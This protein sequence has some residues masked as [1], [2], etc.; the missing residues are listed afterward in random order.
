MPQ[1]S[2]VWNLAQQAQALTQ[3]QWVTDPLFDYTTLLLQADNA[4]N[5]AQNNTFL[6]SS[7]NAFAITRN[8]NTTQGT[9]SPFSQQPGNWSV[10]FG[11]SGNYASSSSTVISST[12][13]TFTIEGWIYQTAATVGTNIPSIIGDMSPTS[14]SA[15]WSFGT[16][17]SGALSFYWYDGSNSLSAV[18]TTTVP[19]NTW[20][21]IA[22]SVNSNT[23]SM[24]INGVQQ[25]LTG[26]TTLTNRGGTNTLTTF[27][28]F[29]AGTTGLYTGYISNFSVLSGTAK[30]SGSFTPSSTPLA[31]GTTNQT[32][33][34]ASSNRFVDANTATTAKTFTITGSATSVQAFSPFAPQ[35]QWTSDVIGGSGYFDGTGDYLSV[36]RNNA[37]LP[38][39]NTDFTFEAWV[40][41]TATPGAQGAII[42]GL[43]EYGTDSDWDLDIN[44][45]LQFALYLNS[46]TATSFRNTT[47][48]VKLNAWNH[49]AAS[50]SGTG[51]NNLKVFVNGVGQ[52]FTTNQTSVGTG[53]RNLSIGADQDGTEAAFTGYISGLRL[54]N[55]QGIY[56]SDFTPPTAPPTTTSGGVTAANTALLLNFT[57]AGIYD[58]TMK[59]DL[60][61][62]ANA[63]VSTSVVK[64]GSGSLYFDGTGDYLIMPFSPW[65]SFGA[66]DFTIEAWV[67]PNSL[68]SAQ[69]IG[70]FRKDSPSVNSDVGWDIY[71]G[72]NNASNEA[73]IYSSTTK[74]AVTGWSLTAGQ[75][76]HI[77]FVRRNGYLLFF[78]NGVQQGSTTSANVSVNSGTTWYT[79][80]GT[81]TAAA[82]NFNG[83][84]DDFRI[85]AG[86]AR[87]TRNFTPPQVALPRQ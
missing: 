24:Y 39:A 32:L 41:P 54:I 82:R 13:S 87:Y 4:A 8:G 6:D 74:Y 79:V 3:Q 81:Y 11:G 69:D 86:I 21:H 10:Y 25:S 76:Q 34:F 67:Y 45:S 9:F 37:F 64:Y 7:S 48:T 38:G 17:A 50:R 15:Y 42:V 77:A 70:S 63:Q 12:T 18:T 36:A 52:S 43:G 56:T 85:T 26:N 75:W 40:Y 53:T 19:L 33:L 16:L 22:V 78:L 60:E 29:S 49:V 57:N 80:V 55:G 28:Q 68:A 73:A 71:V 72:A 23:I 47:T 84:L 65:M 27:A 35:Y 83:Y 62:V 66:G 20:V 31:T 44:S 5:G 59:N 46:T 61:T 51:T 2:G 14:F 1:Y 58:G 30:Y